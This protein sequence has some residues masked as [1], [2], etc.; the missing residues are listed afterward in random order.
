MKILSVCAALA[1]AVGLAQAQPVVIEESSRISAPPGVEFIGGQ[2]GLDG[3]DAVVQGFQSMPDGEGGQDDTIASAYLFHRSGNTWTFVRKLAEGFD[4]NEDDA[5]TKYPVAMKDGILVLEMPQLEIFERENGNWVQKQYTRGGPFGEAPARDI[6]IDSG[7][8]FLGD[9]AWGGTVLEKDGTTGNW[10]A[11]AGIYGDY[12]GDSDNAVGGPVDISANWAA[13]ASPYNSDDLPSPAVNVFQRVPG[14]GWPLNARVLPPAGHSVGDVAITDS[15][16]FVGDYSRFGAGVWRRDSAGQWHLADS[17]RS[18]SDFADG[19]FFD[20]EAY[21]HALEKSGGYVFRQNSSADRGATVVNVFQKDSNGFYRQVAVLVPKPGEGLTGSISVSGNAVLVGNSY[22]QLP[23]SF[24]QPALFQDTFATGNGAG[25]TPVPGS[26]F[27]VV[28]SGDS[29]VFRQSSTAGDAGAVLDA[30]D[31]TSQSIQAD[32]KPTAVNG[33]NRWVGL[34]TRRTDASNYYYVSLRSSGIVQLKRMQGGVFATLDSASVPWTLNRTYRL[35]LESVGT[36]H[37]VYVDGNLVLEAPDD[38][39]SHGSA[40]LLSYRAAADYDNVVVSPRGTQTIYLAARGIVRNPPA[41]N[42]GPWSYAGGTWQWEYDTG[43]ANEIFRQV[44][45]GGDARAVVGPEQII[46]TDQVV[47]ARVRPRTF[48]TTGDPWLGVMA[49]YADASNYVYVSLR[50]SNTLTLRKVVNGN[51][52]QL[53]SAVLTV[54]PNAWYTVRL[55]A[56]GSQLRAYV[57]GRQ[58]LE[59]TDPQPLIGRVGLVGFR[60][61][62]DYDDF[63]AVIP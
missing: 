30:H 19:D 47:E 57:N 11:R 20:G 60:A 4:D 1:G 3:D 9:G 27:S 59:A 50:R 42:P 15:E 45:T 34:A 28:Q 22:F 48:S 24:A 21:A 33:N 54:T 56:I 29:R 32:V 58:V 6:E 12:N 40:A 39:L 36:L 55:E 2:T 5:G 63:R 46:N 38:A 26:Q 53:G 8:I 7:R 44:S 17:L 51:I 31:W 18:A 14:M 43:T 49:R 41:P 10:V 23:A 52:V 13:V 25:W 62:A 61:A 37:R 16:L 35:R